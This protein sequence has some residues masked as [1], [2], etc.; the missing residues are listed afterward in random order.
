M[1]ADLRDRNIIVTGGNSGIGRVACLDFARRGATVSLLCRDSA[2]GKEA[3]KWIRGHGVSGSIILYV[4]DLS[5]LA[6]TARIAR[7]L[8]KDNPRIDVLCNNAGGANAR[9]KLTAEGFET[10]LATNHLSGFLLT[11]ML[12]PGLQAAAAANGSARVVFTS[13]LGHRNSPLDFEDLNLNT[14]Y[15]TLRAY[16]RSKLMNLLTARELYRRHGSAG[17]IASS[18]HPGAVRTPI[19]GKG[20]ILA[21]LLGLVMYPFMRPVEKGAETLIWLASSDESAAREAQGK[22]FVDC[23]QA[24]VAAFASD[25]AGAQLWQLSDQ[26]VAPYREPQPAAQAPQDEATPA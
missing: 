12:I 20:G 10:T 6:D 11:Q 5:S 1:T 15:S 18:F 23:R 2:R 25:A 4:A 7:V 14:G 26:L 13:S 21:G 8:A 3:L 24:D 9:R 22:Y 19:W 17:I 16:G